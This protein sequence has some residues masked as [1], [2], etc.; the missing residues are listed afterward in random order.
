MNNKKDNGNKKLAIIALLLMLIS[1]TVL[2]GTL[3]KYTSTS[4]GTATV[5]VA[6][7]TDIQ[8][9]GES[10]TS[11]NFSF[12]LA[13]T[14]IENNNVLSTQIAPGDKGSFEV[15]FGSAEVAYTYNLSVNDINPSTAGHPAIKFYSDAEMDTLLTDDVN[16][17][18]NLANAQSGFTKTI[19]WQWEYDGG[20]D[21]DD[22][23]DGL[24]NQELN[25]NINISATQ[26][27]TS[28]V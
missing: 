14:K 10:L 12:N 3:A 20:I 9:E 23:Q 26:K 15:D 6:Q 16:I 7:W 8:F 27:D 18:V 11:A 25:F 5:S 4:T 22:T 2:S 24:L 19:Y 17:E 21:S 1:T 13:D 28:A